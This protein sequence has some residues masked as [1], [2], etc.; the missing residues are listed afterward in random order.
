MAQNS[1]I[2]LPGLVDMH[3]HF[4]DPGQTHKEDFL[5]GTTSALAGGYTDVFDMPNN[6]EPV[7]SLAVLKTKIAEAR[8][9][10]VCNVGFHFGSLGDNLDEFARVQPLVHGLKLYLNATTGNYLLDP[11]YLLKIFQAWHSPKPILLHA[12]ADV[13]T[14]ALKITA[15]TNQ[16]THV[17]HVSS[18]QELEPILQA[19]R[20]G[21]PVTCGVTPHHLFLTKKDEKSLG[22]FATMKPSLKS[23]K[24]QDFLWD[25]LDQVDVIES[26]HAPHTIAEKNEGAFGVP[27]LETTLAL[28]LQAEQEGRLR[29]EDILAK[30]AEN[31]RKILGLIEDKQTFIE[32]EPGAYQIR[33]EDLKTKCGWTPFAGRTGWGR[34]KRVTIKDKV[35]FENGELLA[36]PG[37]GHII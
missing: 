33:N 7:L 11:D 17:C 20:A 6:Q 23:Q 29:R 21:L 34:V 26:D 36:K 18:R 27:G 37:S 19:K 25:N 10:V 16:S 1:L 15:Q 8:R 5:S 12:E 24:D 31:P 30:C 35:V 13:I 32:V 4:R 2:R 14:T 22:V 3:V 9:K 28:L